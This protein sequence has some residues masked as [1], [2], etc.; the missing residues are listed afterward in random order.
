LK[1]WS[2]NATG[3]RCRFTEIGGYQCFCQWG[4]CDTR[5][6][7]G[8]TCQGYLAMPPHFFSSIIVVNVIVLSQRKKSS[9]V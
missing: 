1:L 3:V 8:S 2:L 5:P 9:C 7:N 6:M 4:W